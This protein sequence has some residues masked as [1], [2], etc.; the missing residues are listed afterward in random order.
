M[1]GGPLDKFKLDY[2]LGK[3]KVL[4]KYV[5]AYN[6][7]KGK[8]KTQQI[9]TRYFLKYKKYITHKHTF[10]DNHNII[11]T[12]TVRPPFLTK[13]MIYFSGGNRAV[14]ISEAS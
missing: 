1:F 5:D 6:F 13:S 12:R 8:N 14:R 11:I 10:V 9:Y 2:L 4:I 7:G 3:I